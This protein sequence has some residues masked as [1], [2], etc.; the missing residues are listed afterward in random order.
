MSIVRRVRWMSIPFSVVCLCACSS[1]KSEPPPPA[2][3]AVVP[4]AAP[5][6]RGTMAAGSAPVPG[7]AAPRDPDEEDPEQGSPTPAP[8]VLAPEP[9]DSGV[10]L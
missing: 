6:A 1:R 10:S 7:L 3:S 9:A 5:N 2:S 8:P 4:Q